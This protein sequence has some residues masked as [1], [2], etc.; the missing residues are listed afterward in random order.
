M[1]M[2]SSWASFGWQGEDPTFAPLALLN[3][4]IRRAAYERTS[5][6][7]WQH[8]SPKQAYLLNGVASSDSST[9][10]N[11]SES[12]FLSAIGTLPDEPVFGGINPAVTY[13]RAIVENESLRP[14]VAS[15]GRTADQRLMI[16]QCPFEW[17]GTH[18]VSGQFLL[19]ADLVVEASGLYVA[20]GYAFVPL[21]DGYTRIRKFLDFW[22]Y[23]PV[24]I[25]AWMRTA[26]TAN[27]IITAS[28]DLLGI[29]PHGWWVCSYRNAGVS[30]T[31][32]RKYSLTDNVPM[33]TGTGTYAP[34]VSLWLDGRDFLR[35]QADEE[36]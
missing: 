9:L 5:W 8:T 11:V 25:C 17:T 26:D 20:M 34:T 1:S 13:L 21:R 2:N 7:Q 15:D 24:S 3:G 32:Y 6:S 30:Q 35:F 27:D 4:G 31:T 18:Y 33:D 28:Q 16:S 14:S 22:L 36:D 12:D 10:A 19:D 29:S 23:I